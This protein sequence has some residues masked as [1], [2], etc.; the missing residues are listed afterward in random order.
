MEVGLIIA[1]FVVNVVAL[2]CLYNERVKTTG[3]LLI[4]NLCLT[5]AIAYTFEQMENIFYVFLTLAGIAIVFF[6]VRFYMIKKRRE[7]K[8]IDSHHRIDESDD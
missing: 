4:V 7:G 6:G 8:V 3:I 2:N 1:L 5:V